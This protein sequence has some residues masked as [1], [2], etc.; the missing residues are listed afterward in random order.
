M[1]C[2]FC[3]TAKLGFVRNL[4]FGEILEQV[5]LI[6]K[7]HDKKVSNVV[8]MGQGEPFLNFEN[9]MEA[10]E[11]I[12][13]YKDYEI[14]AR[15][16]CISTCGIISGIDKLTEVNKQYR[17][18]ISLHSAEQKTRDVLMPGLKNQSLSKLKSSLISYQERTGRR[19]TIEYIMIKDINDTE[20]QLGFLYNFIRGLKVHINLLPYNNVP[21]DEFQSSSRKTLLAWANFFKSAGYSL[22]V[23]ES[24]GSDVFGACGQLSNRE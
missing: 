1:G 14:G 5:L 10:L 16:I 7:A 4:G 9:V 21:G 17:L 19:I 11:I 24:K 13:T 6:E 15:K 2:C 8:M 3:S 12:N 22:N 20:E 18:A 23:R